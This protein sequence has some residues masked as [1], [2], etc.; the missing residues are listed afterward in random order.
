MTFCHG[1]YT[2]SF[3]KLQSSV[4][5]VSVRSLGAIGGD[6]EKLWVSEL[7]SVRRKNF[8][9]HNFSKSLL[10]APQTLKLRADTHK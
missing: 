8:E 6:L 5:R 4:L 1:V 7:L 3:L 2:R 10:D 9:S